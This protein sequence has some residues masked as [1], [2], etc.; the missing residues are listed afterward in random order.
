[1]Y[2]GDILLGIAWACGITLSYEFCA[3]E[4]SMYTTSRDLGLIYSVMLGAV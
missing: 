1:M 4:T 2:V 3:C